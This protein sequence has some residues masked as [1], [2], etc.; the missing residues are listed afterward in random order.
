MLKYIWQ[1]GCG[2]IVEAKGD[3]VPT[4]CG[5]PMKKAGDKVEIKKCTC[6]CCK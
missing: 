5:K 3:K 6:D 4:C 1:C 2:A